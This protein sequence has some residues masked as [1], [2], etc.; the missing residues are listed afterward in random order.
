[1]L[2]LFIGSCQTRSSPRPDPTAD[3]VYFPLA[4]GQY[5]LYDVSEHLYSLTAS[6][7]TR[8]YQLKEV[9][10]LVYTDLTGQPAYPLQ[11]FRRNQA[12][13]PWQ[14]DSVWTARRTSTEAIRTENGRDFVKL[15]F[16]ATENT[17]WDGNQLNAL[18]GDD[19]EIRNNTLPFRVQ[20]NVFDRTLTV[21]QQND[22]TL[23]SQDKRLEIF[24][25]QVGLV[26]K[27]TRRLQFC[28]SSPACIGTGQVA[29]GFQQIYR[30][31]SYG[32]E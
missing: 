23:L 11:R 29:Y 2:T 19:Y 27:E 25:P 18:G 10:G 24:A 7:V 3:S 26:Y 16:P 17:R 9:V 13:Q 32:K 6:P 5:I 15:V 14:P 1:M 8:T 20:A 22:S 31:Q 4:S 28:S 21:I 12:G 30:I